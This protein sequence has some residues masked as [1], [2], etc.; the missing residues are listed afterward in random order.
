MEDKTEPSLVETK[1]SYRPLLITI[2]V[3]L[4]FFS[5]V[6]AL[7]L[8]WQN[9]NLDK[10]I[11]TLQMVSFSS[12]TAVIIPKPSFT[13]TPS[14][15]RYDALQTLTKTCTEKDDDFYKFRLVDD[16]CQI[17]HIACEIQG[18]SPT[19]RFTYPLS[20]HFMPSG[21]PGITK[22]TFVNNRNFELMLIASST[23]RSLD[24]LNQL[25]VTNNEGAHWPKGPL[26]REDRVITGSTYFTQIG[27][28][29][30]LVAQIE[31]AVNSTSTT[32]QVYF[33]SD[34]QHQSL[35]RIEVDL[36]NN[37]PAYLEFVNQIKSVIKTIEFIP[38]TINKDC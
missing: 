9:S 31:R 23:E 21:G 35:Y 10:Q 30:V 7:Y 16:N 17:T 28:K 22:Y 11:Q 19:I 37:D 3:I 20:L 15:S 6:T 33:F 29:R 18:T 2:L 38:S 24:Q 25:L 4:T 34:P 8:Y 36:S 13:P 32:L 5:T 1:H 14:L 26:E 12:T 27:N